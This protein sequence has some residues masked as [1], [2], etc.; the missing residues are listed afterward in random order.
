MLYTE[1]TKKAMRIAFDAHKNQVDK[2]GLPYI[3]HP[4][5]LAEQM[6]NEIEICVAL[7]HDVAEDTNIT[8]DDLRAE[9]FLEC[10]IE[11]L[12]L[13]K[14]EKEV[15]YFDY[16]EKIKSNPIAVKVKLADLRHN[17]DTS[18]LD[19]IDDAMKARLDKYKRARQLLSD[20][21]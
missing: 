15:N 10:I 3:Y 16:I 1:L 21:L 17:S 20:K 5:N 14:H 19:T 4:I 13:L 11:A 2:T 18:R 6:D 8:F 9:G 12:I 7:L